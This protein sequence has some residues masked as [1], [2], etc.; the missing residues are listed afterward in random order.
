MAFLN[1]FSVVLA[2]NILNN[3]PAATKRLAPKLSRVEI[4]VDYSSLL[5]PR[6]PR[7]ND[8]QS[9]TDASV[10]SSDT[11]PF[12]SADESSFRSNLDFFSL[13]LR[14]GHKFRR[15]SAS[16]ACNASGEALQHLRASP[17]T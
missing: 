1:M 15:Q 8:S 6:N 4:D 3:H 14:G 16:D 5:L 13:R 11:P 9:P 7:C 10:C 2:N 17:L 12:K